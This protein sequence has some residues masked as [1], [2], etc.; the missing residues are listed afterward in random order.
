MNECRISFQFSFR[1]LEVI[2]LVCLERPEVLAVPQE[3][4]LCGCNWEKNLETDP[5]GPTVMCAPN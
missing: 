2:P 1:Q 5:L 4:V 3:P